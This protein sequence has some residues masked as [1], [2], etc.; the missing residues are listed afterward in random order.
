MPFVL[1]VVIPF[2]EASWTSKGTG[3]I[4]VGTER[5]GLIF[6]LALLSE[7]MRD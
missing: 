2:D 7:T 6:H 1:L 3:Y 5:E 4:K